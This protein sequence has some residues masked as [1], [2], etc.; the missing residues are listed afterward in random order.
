MC[1][2]LVNQIRT[3]LLKDVRSASALAK[4][5]GVHKDTMTYFLRGRTKM[6]N[7]VCFEI[8]KHEHFLLARW[9]EEFMKT[10]N[11]DKKIEANENQANENSS[12][13]HFSNPGKK[14]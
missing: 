4:Q 3:I 10:Q 1:Y 9:A 11:K 13:K 6:S 14:T 2:Y 7:S 12:V 5:Y 8:I